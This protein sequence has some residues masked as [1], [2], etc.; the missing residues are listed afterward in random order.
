MAE[1]LSFL[2]S[3]GR[4][5]DVC[6]LGTAAAGAPLPSREPG[7]TGLYF[8]SR[9]E[10]RKLREYPD[11]WAMLPWSGLRALCDRAVPLDSADG[12]ADLPPRVRPA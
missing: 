12:P 7:R 5:W 11:D 10:T 8:L 4:S 2:D 9:D 3:R 1:Q 6:E